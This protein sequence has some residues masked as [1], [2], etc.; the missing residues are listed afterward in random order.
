V[1]VSKSTNYNESNKLKDIE[2]FTNLDK[3]IAE[4]SFEWILEED[5]LV[6]LHSKKFIPK[7]QLREVDIDGVNGCLILNSFLYGVNFILSN[8]IKGIYQ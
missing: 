1:S 7:S 2:Y 6:N 4:R 3:E 8:K 5:G